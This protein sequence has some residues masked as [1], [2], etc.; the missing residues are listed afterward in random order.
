MSEGSGRRGARLRRAAG[1]RGERKAD[2]VDFGRD[3][4]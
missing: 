1:L 3:S 4:A 2:F